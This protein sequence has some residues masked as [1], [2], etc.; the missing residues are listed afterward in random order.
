MSNTTLEQWLQR[1][2]RLHPTEMEL[3]LERVSTVADR[4]DLLPLK[5]PVIT[6]AG[7]NGKGSTV[8]VLEA[9]LLETGRS[10]GSFTSPHLLRFNER[11]RLNGDEVPDS[12][13][14][15]AFVAIDEAR[16]DISL[17][18][19]EF[20]TLAALLVFRVNSPDIVLLEVGLGGRLDSVNIVDA[21]I[22]VIT[23]IDLDH[24]DWLGDTRDKIAVEK[25]GIMRSTRPVVIA[26]PSPPPALMSCALAS[27]AAPIL[28]L[29]RDFTV[30]RDGEHWQA[31]LQA[32][33]QP[34]A[35]TKQRAGSLL[36]ENICAA[37]QALLLLGHD[38][39]DEQLRR[40]LGKARTTG[41]RELQEVNGR[42]YVLDVAHNPAGVTKL[43][44][45]IAA[46]PATGKTIALFCAMADKDISAM[47]EATDGIFDAW[48]LAEQPGNQRAATAADVA[49]LLYAA[50]HGMV[51]INKNIRQAFRRAQ[52]LMTE[53]DRLV[54]FGSFY[55]VA[56]VL[57]LL[58]KD[59]SKMRA[60]G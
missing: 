48:F 9:L 10:T 43:V 35:L 31:V 58:D 11:I 59:R 46:R 54:V 25:A 34:L 37:M 17:T 40:A 32:E 20:A 14:V 27:G 38:F 56:D 15:Q 6:V 51:S 60:T 2:E 57:P 3:G 19:F 21:T 16:G 42:V 39:S 49:E 52:S 24:Q 22:A 7:T 29:G 13:I 4:L 45:F 18:Y 30:I 44:E 47:I 23:A 33:G 53:G 26:D 36:P 5:Q 41:R 8:A 28:C 12:D 55:T 1:L 50:S